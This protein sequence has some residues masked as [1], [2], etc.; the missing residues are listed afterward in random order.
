MKKIISLLTLVFI[1][2]AQAAP[3][4]IALVQEW[5]QFNPVTNNLASTQ[6]LMHFVLRPMVMRDA[7]G[8]LIPDLAEAIP[9]ESTKTVKFATINGNR[10]VLAD[11]KI[12]DQ[13]KWA[14]GKD[15]TCADWWMGWQAGLSPNVST[16]EKAPYTKIEKIEWEAKT[17]KLCKVTYAKDD[18]NFDRD[19][20]PVIPK[21]LEEEVFNKFKDKSEAYDQNSIYVKNPMNKGLYN[22]PYTVEDFQLGSHI[23]LKKNP[24]FFGHPP[25]IEQFIVKHTGDTS[26]LRAQVST[27]EVQIV[28]AVGFP[29]DTA[30]SLDKE[31]SK[32]GSVHKIVLQASPIFQG[33]F[34]NLDH[35]LLKD[36]SVRKA[37]ALAI[38]KKELSKAFFENKIAGAESIF[39]PG[40]PAHEEEKAINNSKAA[41]EL[42]EKAGWKLNARK[43][44]EK[45]G[46]E[47]TL[48]FRVSSGIKIY[49]TIQVYICGQFQKIGVKCSIENQP[50]RVLLGETIQHGDFDL[51]MFGQPVIPDSSL[52]GTF[53]SKEIPSEKNGWAGGN[54]FRWRSE[55]TDKL[56]TAFDQ[57]WKSEKRLEMSKKINHEIQND[58]PFLPLYHRKEAALL[59]SQLKGYTEDIS[60]TD[61]VFPEN[62]TLE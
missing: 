45:N 55:K 6:A 3:L 47:L 57:E 11:W 12:R 43:F 18:W 62:W 19:L 48:K 38:D 40:T 14:D 13:A 44:R 46:Q 4:T 7:R 51:V 39:A 59:P 58:L 1:S 27:G 22:G 41:S 9:S 29:L 2:T 16:N 37:L 23:I 54:I 5:G 26:A 10:K 60:G 52:S 32:P 53:S 15:V 56:L 36:I 49:E 42:L 20:P 24:L 17:P 50:P 61:F 35:D 34:F 30:F 33:I 21:H 31:Y 8:T 25:A 28:S